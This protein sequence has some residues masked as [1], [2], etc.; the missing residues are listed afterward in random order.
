M[1][2]LIYYIP[3]L[4]L[5]S[6][7]Y[8]NQVDCESFKEGTFIWEQESG[9]K[10]F[11]TEFTRIGNLQ[12]EKFENEIDSSRVEWINDCEWRIIPINPDSNADSR[13]YLFKILNTSKDSYTFEFKQSGR[14]QVYSG[15]ATKIK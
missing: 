1:K 8:E 13:A 11:K 6:A 12:I 5:F 15:T 2:K 4:L 7:C 10:K 9:G 14:E 3:L